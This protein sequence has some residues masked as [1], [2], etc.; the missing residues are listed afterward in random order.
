MASDRQPMPFAQWYRGLRGPELVLISDRH[1]DGDKLSEY[2]RP[3]LGKLILLT[4]DQQTKTI[5]DLKKE[6]QAPHYDPLS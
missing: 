1:R 4:G 5:D 2:E 3:R 6:L